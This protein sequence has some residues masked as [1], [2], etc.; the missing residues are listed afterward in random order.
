MF[1]GEKQLERR[2]FR[3][4]EG[5]GGEGGGEGGGGGEGSGEVSMKEE[6]KDKEEIIKEGD[7][8]DTVNGEV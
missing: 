3:E 8:Q 6:E 4:R 1:G 2:G 5:G 7:E